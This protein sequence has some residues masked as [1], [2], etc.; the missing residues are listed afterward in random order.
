MFSDVYEHTLFFRFFKHICVSSGVFKHILVFSSVEAPSVFS[1]VLKRIS[2]GVFKHMYLLKCLKTC[3]WC[4]ET[5][6]VWSV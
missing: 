1:G 3:F 5:H 4:V 2:S 6:I